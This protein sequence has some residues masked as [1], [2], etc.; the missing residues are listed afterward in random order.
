VRFTGL[1]YFDG[2]QW[3]LVDSLIAL[4]YCGISVACVA[5]QYGAIATGP[6]TILAGSDIPKS[7]DGTLLWTSKNERLKVQVH[8]GVQFF[9]TS[10]LGT[11][12]YESD[13]EVVL[14]E[15]MYAYVSPSGTETSTPGILGWL[16]GQDRFSGW[17][18]SVSSNNLTVRVLMNTSENLTAIWTTDVT[19]PMIVF[20]VI[21]ALVLAAAANFLWKR[22]HETDD[23]ERSERSAYLT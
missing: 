11:Q 15:G 2:A 7:P 12:T 19:V 23:S 9:I 22:S 14:P 4:S 20:V 5:N 1:S 21:A 17:T 13:A 18:G 6:D 3:R 16:G 8:P 10:A